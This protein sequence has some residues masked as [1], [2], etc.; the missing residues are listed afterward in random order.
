MA[1]IAQVATNI[2]GYP[3]LNIIDFKLGLVKRL[4]NIDLTDFR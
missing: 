2:K 4:M 3:I 1:I